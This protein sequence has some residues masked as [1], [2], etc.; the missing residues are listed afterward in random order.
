MTARPLRSAVAIVASLSMLM[1]NV[2]ALAQAPALTR[3]DY[4]ACQTGNEATLRDAVARV[5]LQTLRHGL[6]G[7][8]Y[9]ATINQEWR[10]NGV[11]AVMDAS[12]DRSIAEIRS[13][14][15]WTTLWGSLFSKETSSKFAE[16]AAERVYRSEDVK[17]AIEQLAVGVGREVGQRLV[18]ATSDAAEPAARCMH[19]FLGNRF[20]STIAR[21]VSTDTAKEFSI[22]PAK[23]AADVS[24]ADVMSTAGAGIT[25]AVILVVRRQLANMA[26]RLSQRLVGA[27]LGRLVAVV[28]GGIGALL[29][30]KDIWQS[31]HGV[32]PIIAEE[33]KSVATKDKVRS[34]LAVAL[35]QQ[36]GEHIDDIASKA[37]DRVIE[38]WRDFQRAHAMVVELAED[39]ADFRRFLDTVSPERLPRLDETV[40]LVI[41]EEGRPAVLKRL[42]DGTL[43]EAVQVMDDAGFAIARDLRSLETTF[44]WRA[45][46]GELLPK[47]IVHELHRRSP[48]SQFT[49]ASLTRILALDDKVAIHR[50]S[51][52]KDTVREP[53]LELDN[54]KLL[55]LARAL[56]EPELES[57]SRYLT[58][59]ARPAAD[60][61][62]NAI[63]LSPAKLTLLAA[64]GVRDAVL[65][66]HDQSAAVGMVVRSDPVFD[67]ISFGADLKLVRDGAVS[68]WLLWQIYPIALSLFGGIAAVMLL[69]MLRLIVGRRPRVV[70]QVA[71][72]GSRPGK[73]LT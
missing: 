44:K 71:Q 57:L 40:A 17:K 34:E 43:R 41:A 18:L 52:L 49:R 39:N 63:A 73:P 51:G 62:L 14:T 21:V 65:A 47:V 32:L 59:L 10:R 4:E 1:P 60:R 3:A 56:T 67:F 30:A 23:G 68:P 2:C 20:G 31:R 35:T 46:A 66:S 38:I 48:P 72:A 53:L 37:A 9:A 11:D 12:I 61:V 45:L 33:M 24:T 16:A 6:V 15:G 26:S 5:T 55:S 70:V 69:I 13:E 8:D 22:D 19:A 36:I 25:G 50:L 42:A 29:I 54:A 58:G 64:P 28:A 7:I 27:V